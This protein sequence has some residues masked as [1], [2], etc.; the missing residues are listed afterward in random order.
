VGDSFFHLSRWT[1]M[2]QLVD[3]INFAN[4]AKR[5]GGFVAQHYSVYTH[6]LTVGSH[7]LL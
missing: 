1:D 3:S 4:M 7:H 5:V 6:T 2:T